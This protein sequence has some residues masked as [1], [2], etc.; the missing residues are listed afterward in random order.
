MRILVSFLLSLVLTSCGGGSGGRS[1]PSIEV[2]AD[3]ICAAVGVPQTCAQMIVSAHP[4][5]VVDD[6]AIGGLTLSDLFNGYTAVW[7][8]GPDGKNGPQPP[9]SKAAHP[10]RYVVV[11]LGGDDAYAG[12]SSDQYRNELRSVVV[13]I[14]AGGGVP[15]LTG[16]VPLKASGT[17]YFP[18]GLFDQSVVD[19]AVAL[20]A[21]QHQVA[22]ET[23]ALDAHW[24][25]VPFDPSTDTVDGIHRTEPALRRLVQ[26]LVDTI[27]LS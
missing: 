2:N 19:R 24:D 4:D 8:G 25:M 23:G 27:P 1:I 11:E 9:F 20:N 26:R 7:P 18:G 13:S 5:W 17:D 14:L 10:S 6:R 12:F 3:S 22:S 16:I 21:I 15:V